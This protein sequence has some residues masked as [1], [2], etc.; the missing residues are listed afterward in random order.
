MIDIQTILPLAE[1]LYPGLKKISAFIHQNPELGMEEY[2]ASA[3]AE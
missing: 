1:E 2:Q 3:K